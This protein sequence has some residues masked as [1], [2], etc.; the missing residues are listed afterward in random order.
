MVGESNTD[1]EE[2]RSPIETAFLR[3]E[4]AIKRVIGRITRSAD[5]IEDIAQEAFLRSVVAEKQRPI[6]NAR[7]YLFEAARNIAR[8]ARTR[9]TR[10][11]LQEVEDCSTLDV[12]SNEPSAEEIVISRERFTMFCETIAQLPPQC[13]KVLLMC[14]VYGKSHKEISHALGISESTVEKHVGTGLARCAAYIAAR[15]RGEVRTAHLQPV[16]MR[17]RT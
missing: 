9:K 7:A 1:T 16:E 8:T 14:K 17:R 13:R 4:R 11:I 15:E 2:K 12:S 5:E 10:N 6:D 3:Y